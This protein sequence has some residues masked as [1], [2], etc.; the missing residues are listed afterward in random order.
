VRD[1][2]T[3]SGNDVWRNFV[4]HVS[5]YVTLAPSSSIFVY[6]AL[7]ALYLQ[8]HTQPT[9]Q[10]ERQKQNSVL[11]GCRCIRGQS[12][13]TFRGNLMS[14]QGFD[15]SLNNFGTLHPIPEEPIL[16]YTAAIT[17]RLNE[18]G[19]LW[20]LAILQHSKMCMNVTPDRTS[21]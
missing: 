5:F 1:I 10:Y 14:S 9:S 7:Y 21:Q 16:R 2:G 6:L 3:H 13:L 4:L 11:L 12:I 20:S 18:Q 19:W 17:S 15:R 8:C